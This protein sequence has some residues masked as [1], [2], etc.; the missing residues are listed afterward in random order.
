VNLFVKMRSLSS[1]NKRILLAI[2][3]SK[4]LRVKA[5]VLVAI[6]FYICLKVCEIFFLV[7]LCTVTVVRE[8]FR[9]E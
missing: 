1:I 8:I 5:L 2:S 3:W 6:A 7:L 4:K 9:C